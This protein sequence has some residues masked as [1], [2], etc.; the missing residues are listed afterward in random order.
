MYLSVVI[1][2]CIWLIMLC[3]TCIDF[4]FHR[5]HFYSN[6]SSFNLRL[7]IHDLFL[8][9]F[10]HWKSVC[11]LCRALV[12]LFSQL[13]IKKSSIEFVYILQTV[14]LL[15]CLARNIL[16]TTAAIWNNIFSFCCF[17]H[18]MAHTYLK[19]LLNLSLSC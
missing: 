4:Q 9:Q 3:S 13:R 8:R 17:R 19:P 5:K 7:I 11:I 14:K 16:S 18:L 6:Q 10:F 15:R 2:N 12:S 1:F